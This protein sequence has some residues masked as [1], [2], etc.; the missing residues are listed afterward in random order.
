M[1]GKDHKKERFSGI[2][3]LGLGQDF[4]CLQRSKIS[5]MDYKLHQFV[6]GHNDQNGVGMNQ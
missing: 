2:P 5:I 4:L 6:Q 3:S 1:Y